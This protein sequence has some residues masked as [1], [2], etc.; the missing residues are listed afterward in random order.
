MLNFF[1]KVMFVAAAGL[2][3]LLFMG[4]AAEVPLGSKSTAEYFEDLA[5]IYRSFYS[6]TFPGTL[7]RVKQETATAVEQIQQG[8]VPEVL[9]KIQ[10]GSPELEQLVGDLKSNVITTVAERERKREEELWKKVEAMGGSGG[11]QPEESEQSPE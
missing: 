10:Q 2:F 7:D 5:G 8:Q 6:T 3:L 1:V 4:W 9:K 11:E